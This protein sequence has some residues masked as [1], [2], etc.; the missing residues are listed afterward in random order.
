MRIT[1]IYTVI[2]II[3]GRSQ[4]DPLFNDSNAPSKVLVEVIPPNLR[5]KAYQ[6]SDDLDQNRKH[7]SRV[8]QA[9][10]YGIYYDDTDYDYL[11]HLKP[12]GE[13]QGAI[14]IEAPSK[15]K[16]KKKKGQLEFVE[17]QNHQESGTSKKDKKVTIVLPDEVLPS[18]EEMPIEFF[19]QSYIPDDIQGFQPDMD[20]RLRETLEALDDD[21]YV[22]NELND[23]FFSALNAEEL[24][25][26]LSEEQDYEEGEA[27]ESNWQKEFQKFKK[28]QR[29]VEK[30]IDEYSD[31]IRSRTTGNYSMSSSIM[32]RNDKLRLLDDQFEK[33]E[34]EYME[35]D[36]DD[37]SDVESTSS[38]QVRQDFSQILDEFLCKYEISGRKIVPKLGDTEQDQLEIIRQELGQV[39]L[40]EKGSKMVTKTDKE[41]VEI[42]SEPLTKRQA[43]DC[44]SILSTYS[45]LENHPTLI[46]EK[47]REKLSTE[48]QIGL[49][50]VECTQE[51][52]S[53]DS[54]KN[55][56]L[57]S[58]RQIEIV[59]NE[60]GQIRVN[61]GI[62]RSK[63]ESREEK[64]QRK[65]SVKTE[66]KNRR[67]EKKSFKQAFA[68]EHRRQ[69]KI[70][71]NL[72]KNFV[73]AVHLE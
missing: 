32:H 65:A 61:L 14:Y 47:P 6:V 8:G 20:P 16:E 57:D 38:S 15:D 70:F 67:L 18:R 51:Y 34:K 28:S 36:D 25:E 29:R 45:N 64:K 4:R 56:K 3:F 68:K 12:I 73:N 72:E 19:N 5:G 33:I 58:E 52:N 42:E 60:N 21:A 10:L 22:E 37:D 63:T 41:Y 2:V 43:W 9:A 71:Q 50:T 11:Q 35:D 62:P 27:E 66:R 49:S 31:D 46:R 1:F 39:C 55:E 13:D 24:P 40:D 7:E 54:Q 44:Q 53:D 69:N 48:K 59:E 23:D 30:D 26:E 17:D